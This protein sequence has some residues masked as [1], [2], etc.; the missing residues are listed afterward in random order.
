MDTFTGSGST[1]LACR[2]LLRC[3]IGSEMGESEFNGAVTRLES[4]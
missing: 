4:N 1:A 3:F 2:N